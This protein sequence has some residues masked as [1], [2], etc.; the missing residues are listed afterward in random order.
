M[1]VGPLVRLILSSSHLSPPQFSP[2]PYPLPGRTPN[3]HGWDG[4]AS[5]CCR[6]AARQDTSTSL[7]AHPQLAVWGSSSLEGQSDR[8][9]TPIPSITTP[10]QRRRLPSG[11]AP[12]S[13][14]WER[15][16]Q[17]AAARRSA[18]EEGTARR[19]GSIKKPSGGL[20]MASEIF[21]E[22]K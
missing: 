14:V 11:T 10:C 18:W 16:V 21:G 7:A 9:H 17:G 13:G 5:I 15:S 22:G 3:E 4:D 6:R 2:K 12:T 20:Q 19:R 1:L 8:S